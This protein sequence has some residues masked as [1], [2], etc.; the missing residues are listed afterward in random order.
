[1]CMFLDSLQQQ[2]NLLKFPKFQHIN[3]DTI[4]TT[5]RGILGWLIGNFYSNAS[6]LT[7]HQNS[8]QNQTMLCDAIDL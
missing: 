4:L 5:V 1:M 8:S 2:F 6:F 7:W 3:T